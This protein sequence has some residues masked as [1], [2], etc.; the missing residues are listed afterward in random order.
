MK[1]FRIAAQAVVV[2]VC[3]VFGVGAQD[4]VPPM[5][6]SKF[7]KSAE[8]VGPLKDGLF[9]DQVSMYNGQTEFVVTDASLQGNS[10]LPVSLSRRFSVVAQT[11]PTAYRGFGIWDVEVPHLSGTFATGSRKWNIGYNGVTNRCSQFFMADV[12]PIVYASDVH[13]GVQMHIPGRGDQDLIGMQESGNPMPTDGR[14]YI[15]GTRDGA[16]FQ[17]KPTTANGYPGEGFIALLPDGTRYTFDVALEKI[18]VSMRLAQ[19][20][21]VGRIK[22]YLL[23]SRVED[24]FGNWVNY[25][26]NSA[27]KVTSIVSN[28]ARS[29][30]FAY[31]GENIASANVNGRVWTYGYSAA[32]ALQLTSVTAPDGSR[33]TYRYLVDGVDSTYMKPRYVPWDGS[34]GGCPDQ[35]YNPTSFTLM[36]SHP[37]GASGTFEFTYGR[38]RKSG[39]PNT[40]CVLSP[41]AGWQ[42]RTPDYFDLYV[43]RSKVI[44]GPGLPPLTWNYVYSL[45]GSGRTNQPIPCTTCSSSKWNHVVNPDGS[46]SWEQYGTLYQVNDGRLL[47]KRAVSAQGQVLRSEELTYVSDSEAATQPFPGTYGAFLYNAEP[48]SARIRPVKTA[49]VTQDGTAFTNTVNSFDNFA[50]PLATHRFSPWHSRTDTTEYFDDLGQWITGQTG[51]ITNNDTGLVVSQATYNAKA[52]PERIWSFG[53]LRQT[54]SYHADGQPSSVTDGNGNPTTLS[55]WKLGIPQTIGFADGAGLQA[56]VDGNG[57]I[58]SVTDE[59]GFSTSYTY[60]VMGRMASLTYPAGDTVAWNATTQSFQ[61]VQSDEYGL[62]A[63]H[64][65][66]VASTGNARKETYFDALW[67][68]IVVREYDAA[69]VAGTQ[70]FQRIAY[71]EAGRTAF[72]AYPGTTDALTA[73]IWTEYDA[74]GRVTSVGQ[75]SEQGV[76]LTTTDYPGFGQTRV[77]SARGQI[78]TSGYQVFDQPD[79][80]K[81]VWIEHPEGARTTLSLDVFGKPLSIKRGSADGATYVT[82][83]YIYDGNQRLCKAVEPETGSTVSAYDSEGNVTWSAAGLNLPSANCD[84]EAA[85]ASGR[86]ID[87]TYDVRNRLKTLVF[88]DANGSQTWQYTADG[89]PSSVTTSNQ[90]G[91]S[92]TVNTY[93][94]N[95]RRLLVAETTGQGGADTWALGYGYDANGA[96]ASVHY[97][98]GDDVTFAPNALGQATRAGTFVVGVTYYPNGGMKSFTYGNGITHAMTQNARQLPA[99]VIDANVL[100]NAYSYDNVGNVSGIGDGLDASRN[101]TM[102]YDGMDRLIE[103]ISPAFGGDGVMRY[104]YDVLDNLRSAKLAGLKDHTYWYDSSNRLTNVQDS[105]GATTI[106][107]GYDPQGN[108]SN[109]NGQ[110]FAFDYGNRLRNVPGKESYRYDAQGRRVLSESDSGTIRSMY[111]QDGV[112]RAVEDARQ[113]KNTQYIHLNGSLVAEVTRTV[114]PAVP[115]VNVVAFSNTGAYTVSWNSVSGA[116]RYVLQEQQAGQ[117]WATVYDGALASWSA[118]GKAEGSYAYR[119][120]ACQGATCGGWSAAAQVAVAMPPLQAPSISAPASAYNGTIIVS[121]TATAG[122]NRYVLEERAPS[123]AWLSVADGAQLTATLTGRVDGTYAYRVTAWNAAGAG[124]V[125]L[126]ASVRMYLR[127]AQAPVLSAPTPSLGGAIS[128][129]WAAIG[130]AQWYRLEESTDGQGW[131]VLNDPLAATAVALQRNANGTFYYRA[132]ACNPAGCGDYSAPVG[133]QVVIAPAYAPGVSVPV[134]SI[135]GAYTVTWNGVAH[136]TYYA[137]QERANGGNWSVVGTTAGVASGISG[138]ADGIYSYRVQAC[139]A[140]GCGPFSGEALVSVLHP[141]AGTPSTSVPSSVNGLSYTVTW[142]AVPRA[143]SY[144]IEETFP[145]GGSGLYNGTTSTSLTLTKEAGPATWAYRVQACN[146]SGC[147]PWSNQA[148]VYLNV[149]APPGVPAGLTKTQRSATNCRITW[150]AVSGAAYY[151]LSEN[152][153]A[154]YTVSTTSMTIDGICPRSV[155]VAA[156][157]AQGSCSGWSDPR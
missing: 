132:T 101:R 68:P 146:S 27:G 91:A 87:R 46:Q 5:E 59:N 66:Q 53:L 139:N 49:V 51:K 150:S 12:P 11:S 67:R 77:T 64:W 72:S 88:P 110:V 115:V 24:R 156:C 1:G 90:A 149:P 34:G 55:S 120:A 141:V 128:L 79:Y 85:A 98:S 23:A 97:P 41:N 35:D 130:S 92:Q 83:S 137:L 157:N 48:S 70:R 10:A 103:A 6:Y 33:Y 147:G 31:V 127:P 108:L 138:R 60:D 36:A 26:Y 119:A 4:L 155:R 106:G 96:L 93:A 61:Q 74:L 153:S 52:Q 42:L 107:L 14:S 154:G 3:T 116:T 57:W 62:G 20:L 54:I 143:T 43:L 16:R 112:L 105:A 40:A 63:G 9:G 89:K 50:R 29:I 38:Q 144:N 7:L 73:G 140:D 37:S 82:R 148:S 2:V 45:G 152:N 123:G 76:L 94:Y 117:A 78:T 131:T 81:P 134:F 151:K 15:W 44:T 102:Q 69:D 65:R 80:S 8:M 133:V 136:S 58:T 28:D 30:T 99:R 21:S 39:V 114:A 25:Q 121:W 109:R 56:A 32:D 22:I 111:G 17:C 19:N 126:E 13:K 18:D 124:P 118:S 75:D 100:D 135:D 125:S 122:A 142:T 95:K 145:S 84:L 47:G 104:T 71:D 129:A 113:G 86:R